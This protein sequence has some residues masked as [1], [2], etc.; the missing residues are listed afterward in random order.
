MEACEAVILVL[1]LFILQL[2]QCNEPQT[3]LTQNPDS[4]HKSFIASRC[5]ETHKAHILFPMEK[6]DKTSTSLFKRFH[7]FMPVLK[8]V[9]SNLRGPFIR[10]LSDVGRQIFGKF[11]SER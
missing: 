9:Q 3:C 7:P 1:A 4:K 11:A 10:D 5:F 8:S 2:L 6:R